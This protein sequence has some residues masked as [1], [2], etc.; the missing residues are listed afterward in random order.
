MKFGIGQPVPRTEDTRLLTGCGSYVDDLSLPGQGH[1]YFLRSPYAHARILSLDTKAAAAMPGVRAI[2]TGADLAAAGVGPIACHLRLVQKDG[3]LLK[4]PRRPALQTDRVR[5][6]GDPVCLIVADTLEQAR[7]AAEDILIAYDPLPSTTSTSGTLAPEAPQVWEEAPG[8]LCFDWESGDK[9][10]TAAAFEKAA[11]V[12]TLDL[13]NNRVSPTSMEGRAAIADYDNADERMTLYVSSQ[14]VFSIQ[15]QLMNDVFHLPQE[16]IRVVTPDVGG[17]FGMKL[18]MYPE[19]VAILHAARVL[20]QPVRW[21]SD[22]SEAFQSDDHG[23]D[24]VT[25]AELALDQD[26][27]FLALKVDTIAN[28]GAY[29][30]NYGPFVAT[31]AGTAM[32]A[33]CYTTPAIYVSVKGVFTNTAPVDAYRGAGRPEAAYCLERIVDKAGRE[34]GLGPREIRLRNFIPATA[35]PYH[36]ALGHIYDTGDFQRNMTDAVRLAGWDGFE[37]RRRRSRAAGKRRGIGLA[38]YIE[39][40]SGGGPEQSTVRVHGDGRV[41]VLIGT[42][43]NGQ[44]HETAYKQITATRLGIGPED[45]TIIQGDTDLISFG[46]GTGGSRS[47]PVGGAALSDAALNVVEQMRLSAANML[48][49]ATTDIEFADGVFTIAGTDRRVSFRDIAKTAAPDAGATAFEG[50]ARWAPPTSTFP[51]GTHI[52]EIEVDDDTGSVQI[53]GY[54]VVDDFG[55]VLNPLLL[56]GQIHGGIAQGLGQ[57]LLEEAVY[58]RDSGQLLTG[59]FMDYAMPRADHLPPINIHLN[60]VPSTT[61]ALGMKG[62]G[63]AGA[64][65][66]PPAVINAIVD[67]L[68]DLGVDHIDMP[69]TPSRVW[70]LLHRDTAATTR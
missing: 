62:A 16:K 43:S 54:V 69:A 34:T 63:E 61:N 7:D 50:V 1:G 38:S 30:S 22:R 49:A 15:K 2:I 60:S 53:V 56:K 9:V 18:F 27:R 47:I 67:A 41:T 35:M 42:Q 66:A 64:I 32:L 48:E 13:V 3:S 4:L 29:L 12:V 14:G 40:C 25:R 59:S 5:F 44:G 52:C 17:G 28:M 55:T 11:R 57:A 37:E 8:N 23:R 68:A 70:A 24:N 20:G 65:G 19:Y 6:V 58:D 51:N 10:A 21:A 46:S 26:G 33:G 45:I 31:Q 39:A 36:T